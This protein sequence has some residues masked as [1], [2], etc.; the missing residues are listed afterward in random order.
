MGLNVMARRIGVA[1]VL[2]LL[3][4]VPAAMADEATGACPP[5]AVPLSDAPPRAMPLKEA[6]RLPNRPNATLEG[7]KV[8]TEGY[9]IRARPV[10]PRAAASACSAPADPTTRIWLATR[11]PT[12]L[13][14]RISRHRALVAL[15]P[16][17]LIQ[18]RLGQGQI[19]ASLI[20]KR[21]RIVGVLVFNPARKSAL[22]KTRG[23]LWELRA[24]SALTPCPGASCPAP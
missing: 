24:V 9:L 18:A 15:V 13:K 2:S 14:G 10:R 5:A 20:N 12:S 19:P 17:A 4:L 23:S 6:I 16:T 3:A 21:V 11:K 7:A 1:V 22:M 8:I